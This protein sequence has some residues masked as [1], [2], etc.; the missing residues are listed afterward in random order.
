MYSDAAKH[1]EEYLQAR[2]EVLAQLHCTKPESELKGLI[3]RERSKR[4][5]RKLQQA[6]KPAAKQLS[7]I[8]IY[9][10]DQW[11]VIQ[12][13]S[14]ME[15][16]IRQRNQ[17]HFGQA[18]GTPFT[19]SPL[20]ELCGWHGDTTFCHAVHS[21]TANLP[22]DLPQATRL[23]LEKLQQPQHTVP[24]V[25]TAADLIKGYR[26]WREDTSTSPS[27]RH[28]GHYRALAKL[29]PKIDPT[30]SFVYKFF[31]VQAQIANACIAQAFILP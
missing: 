13:L 23:I 24:V 3:H 22:P 30:E 7:H 17:Q 8:K 25:I 21:N 29:V 14:E 15:E 18:K 27:G 2:A 20:S 9:R 4:M 11:H 10:D 6:L 19:V 12:D 16:S 5:Y 1:R 28:L 31:G 26:H